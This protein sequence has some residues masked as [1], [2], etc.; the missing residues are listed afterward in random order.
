MSAFIHL[1]V[2][3]AFSAQYGTAAPEQLVRAAAETGAAAA[4]ITDRDGLYGAVRH[5]RAC[6]DANLAPIVGVSLRLSPC[7]LYTS[8][9][10]RDS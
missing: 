9:S 8:P 6:I 3:S 1:H 2:A 5:I 10:P 7:L 4:A